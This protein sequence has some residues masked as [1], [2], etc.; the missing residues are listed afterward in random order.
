MPGG[1]VGIVVNPLSGRD[2][3][4]LVAHASVFPNAE[5]ANMVQRMLTSLKA[6]GVDTVLASTDLSGVSAALLRA[7][8]TRSR[9]FAWPAVQFLDDD[10][11]SQTAE[12]TAN[13]V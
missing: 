10:A 13:A 3:R 4:R 8:R 12:D 6:V 9:R 5:K 1:I 7:V 2:I 11:I